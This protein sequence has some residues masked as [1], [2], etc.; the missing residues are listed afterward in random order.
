MELACPTHASTTVQ[1]EVGRI[2][3]IVPLSEN[4]CLTHD[5]YIQ[6]GIFNHSVERHIELNPMIEWLVVHWYPDIFNNRYKRVKFQRTE[7]C[8]EG[9]PK[10]DNVGCEAAVEIRPR[11]FPD[12]PEGA[13]IQEENRLNRTL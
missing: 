3:F 4:K 13:T 12:A 5:G 9:S 1:E 6:I 8:N 7:A 11:D 2:I 10:T